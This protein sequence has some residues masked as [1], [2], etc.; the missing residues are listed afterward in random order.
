MTNQ[1]SIELHNSQKPEHWKLS[2]CQCVYVY[3]FERH[4]F[5]IDVG[6]QRKE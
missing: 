6:Q 5:S 2:S 1:A 4:T 3:H